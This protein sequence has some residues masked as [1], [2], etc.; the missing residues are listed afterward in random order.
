MRTLLLLKERYELQDLLLNDDTSID[1][2]STTFGTPVN[3]RGSSNYSI[4][5]TDNSYG[6]YGSSTSGAVGCF[7][8]PV[9]SQMTSYILEFD[10]YT[11]SQVVGA[12][13]SLGNTSNY[14]YIYAKDSWDSWKTGNGTSSSSNESKF[15]K[16]ES[17]QNKWCHYIITR[18]NSDL[19]FKI[20]INNS[21]IADTSVNLNSSI[22]SSNQGISYG[23]SGN[24]TIQIKNIKVRAL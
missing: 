17:I 11:S 12:G 10:S 19:N 23:Y 24:I 14:A 21:L 3:I 9:L 6:L 22:S 1:K 15:T 4:S 2:S 13:I 20:Y 7:A 8:L 16:S 18:N 5:Y